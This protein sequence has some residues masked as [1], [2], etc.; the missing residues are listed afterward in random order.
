MFAKV[1]AEYREQFHTQILE[2]NVRRM[3]VFSIYIIVLQVVLNIINIVKPSDTQSSDIMVYVSLS[4]FTL[5]VGIVFAI[6]FGLAKKGKFKSLALKRGM[7]L[8]LLYLYTVIQMTFCTLNIISTGGINSYIIGILIIGLAPIIRPL[9]SILSIAACFAYVLL[10]IY[11]R[12]DV[13]QTWDSIILT[14]TW[15]NL[16][17]ITA[18]TACISVFIYAMYVA[19]FLKSMELQKWGEHL[20]ATVRE[21][22][23]ALEEKTEAAQVASRAKSEFLARMSHEIRTPLNAI[24]GMAQ[25][26]RKAAVSDK[27]RLSVDEITIA[28]KHLLD[29]LNDVLDMSNI[30]S[31]KLELAREPFALRA[32]MEEVVHIISPRCQ[33]KQISF[34]QNAS[35][36]P[37]LRVIGDKL[38][39]RQ[40][41][42]NILD[43]SVKYTPA[44]GAISL[45]ITAAE[46]GG[47]RTRVS[48]AVTDDGIG[49]NEE[50]ISK[51][52]TAFEHID[53]SSAARLGGIGLGLA[54]SQ[55]LV[56]R[57]GGQIAVQ[58]EPGKGSSFV[59]SVVLEHMAETDA[60]WDTGGAAPDL[61]GKRILIVEDIEI[62]RMILIE[63]LED[64]HAEMEEAED[65]L[66]ALE[67]FA[68]SPEGY[69]DFI[70]MDIQM[71]N[72][73]GYDCT[74]AIRALP[75]AD[76]A[77]VPIIAMS[78]N[79]YQEDIDKSIL[80]GMGG[81]LAKPVDLDMVFRMLFEKIR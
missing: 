34:T 37:N 60:G 31:G 19:N 55:N 51:L 49:M 27:A 53:R 33:E 73:D 5:L 26:V 25:I 30:E 41:L 50:Q 59:F 8:T 62:N 15:T 74:R 22:T 46:E 10:A 20:E 72:M 13:S 11:T 61:S 4:L 63:L 52:F 2:D 40:V 70:F 12:R 54:I 71:P 45:R 78:A 36:A 75:R 76:A 69:Y 81:H 56:N 80:S 57:M 38:R 64:T 39:L 17:I 3:H 16:I 9:Q 67:K 43:N 79:A 47:N 24:I 6:L 14:D 1:P 77:T 65:G 29:I 58:S 35:E 32:A 7:V 42:I 28:S 48:F 18:L 23:K 66:L 68:A 21:R 44:R